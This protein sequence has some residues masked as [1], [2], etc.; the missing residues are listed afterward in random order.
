MKTRSLQ[1]IWTAVGLFLIGYTINAFLKDRGANLLFKPALVDERHVSNDYF[2][3]IIIGFVLFVLSYVGLLYAHQKGPGAGVNGIPLTGLKIMDLSQDLFA[4]YQLFFYVLFIVV[5]SLTLLQFWGQL[6]SHGRLFQDANLPTGSPPLEGIPLNSI[7][8]L[9]RALT[10]PLNSG[11]ICLVTS[12]DAYRFH[13]AA[14]AANDV[15]G[16]PCSATD[17]KGWDGGSDFI[18]LLSP[19]LLIGA[20]LLGW[21]AAARFSIYIWIRP[22]FAAPTSQ[23][24]K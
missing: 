19:F 16:S 9:A 6:I 24:V 2:S 17:M 10:L 11:R 3:I 15:T 23:R 22:T 5:P 13:A 1:S 4:K 20:T 18:P 21:I 12:D 7:Q 14:N 8:G